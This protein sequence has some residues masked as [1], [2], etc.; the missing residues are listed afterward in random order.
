MEI[1]HISW[2]FCTFLKN[3]AHFLKILHISW[4]FCPFLEI[5]KIEEWKCSKFL[6]LLKHSENITIGTKWWFLE[7]LKNFKSQIFERLKILKDGSVSGIRHFNNSTSSSGQV[8]LPNRGSADA[9]DSIWKE[10]IQNTKTNCNCNGKFM[11]H[12][13]GRARTPFFRTI[14]FSKRKNYLNFSA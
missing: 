13:R 7:N 11:Y 14:D 6:I 8:G 9:S 12:R 10:A 5:F 3:F 4:K 2:K 1:L